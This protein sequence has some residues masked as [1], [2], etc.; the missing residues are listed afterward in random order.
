MTT[1]LTMTFQKRMDL[2]PYNLVDVVNDDVDHD[3]NNYQDN[4]HDNNASDTVMIIS[5]MMTMIY[6]D[7]NNDDLGTFQ[8]GVW[9][10]EMK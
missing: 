6:I 3:D 10:K 1:A 4:D 8:L 9:Y 5:M 7:Q 2:Q